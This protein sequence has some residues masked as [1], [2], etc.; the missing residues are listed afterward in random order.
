MQCTAGDAGAEQLIVQAGRGG[1]VR[2]GR[3]LHY[4]GMQ[5]LNATKSLIAVHHTPGMRGADDAVH[6]T[7]KAGAGLSAEP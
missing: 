6:T 7:Q 2:G 3:G 4:T 1:G 5:G